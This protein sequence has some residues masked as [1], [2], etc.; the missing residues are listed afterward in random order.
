VLGVF[1]F[2]GT[3]DENSENNI[4]DGNSTTTLDNS[5]PVDRGLFSWFLTI[6][7]LR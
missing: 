1:G 6:I 4:E 3:T 7:Q 5:M 2:S